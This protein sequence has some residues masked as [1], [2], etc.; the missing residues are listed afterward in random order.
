MGARSTSKAGRVKEPRRRRPAAGRRTGRWQGEPRHED[1]RR[2]A[3]PS[4]LVVDDDQ[5]LASTLKDFLTR[6]G[7]AVEV[8]LSGAEAL[9]IQARIPTSRW[10]WWTW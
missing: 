10:R 4:I 9:A 2:I 7:Y 8:A 3:R 5:S 1:R 6:E